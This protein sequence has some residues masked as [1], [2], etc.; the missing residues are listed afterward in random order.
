MI[1]REHD[2]YIDKYYNH[3]L[4]NKH[5][6]K[7]FKNAQ[8]RMKEIY[9]TAYPRN[10]VHDDDQRLDD[11]DRRAERSVDD[12]E[13][14]RRVIHWHISSFDQQCNTTSSYTS[15]QCYLTKH[16]LLPYNRPCKI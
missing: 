11:D 13:P 1:E 9:C 7:I 12:L 6:D 14:Q 2:K 8:N 5:E 15:K 4:N 10:G 3:G 16:S